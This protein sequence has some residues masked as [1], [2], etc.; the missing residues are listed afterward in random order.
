MESHIPE[1]GSAMEDRDVDLLWKQ[2]I[3]F[4][5]DPEKPVYVASYLYPMF[6]LKGVVTLQ[7]T[8]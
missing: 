4:P 1:T 5:A 2:A 7:R 8:I 3:I 6:F